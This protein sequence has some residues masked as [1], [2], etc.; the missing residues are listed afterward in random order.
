MTKPVLGF[1]LQPK[2]SARLGDSDFS[3][4][5]TG[6]TVVQRVGTLD[7]DVQYDKEVFDKGCWE[8]LASGENNQLFRALL[9]Y[10]HT[11][12]FAHIKGK[13]RILSG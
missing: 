5:H 9:L 13:V 2:H 11:Y 6:R 1:G 7:K 12:M 3:V 8:H 10:I 4:E